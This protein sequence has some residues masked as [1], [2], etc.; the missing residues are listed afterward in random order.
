MLT[1]VDLSAVS[2]GA[3]GRLDNAAALHRRAVR[4]RQH[5][6]LTQYQPYARASANTTSPVVIRHFCQHICRVEC[7]GAVSY[8][9]GSTG[10]SGNAFY[11]ASGGG[12]FFHWHELKAIG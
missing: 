9:T 8:S 3:G 7:S 5:R 10:T 4:P 6:P 1:E 11:S 12:E 2:V